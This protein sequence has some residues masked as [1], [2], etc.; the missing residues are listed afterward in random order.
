MSLPILLSVLRAAGL[1]RQQGEASKGGAASG[2]RLS[3]RD[4]HEVFWSSLPSLSPSLSLEET[5][6]QLEDFAEVLA[7]V[8]L[9]VARLAAHAKLRHGCHAATAEAGTEEEAAYAAYAACAASPDGAGRNGEGSPRH[10]PRRAAPHDAV[11]GG[12]WD[13]EAAIIS[14]LPTVVAKLLVCTED[15]PASI[16]GSIAAEGLSATAFIG[17]AL[18][19]LSTAEG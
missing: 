4:V 15:P 3:E 16:V 17:R 6:L 13:E 19:E 11:A 10:L 9:R 2:V 18:L 1:L 8:S 14:A 7:R 12:V 5:E